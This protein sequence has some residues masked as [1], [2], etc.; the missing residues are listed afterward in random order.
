MDTKKYNASYTS[1]IFNTN[2]LLQ[3]NLCKFTTHLHKFKR[4]FKIYLIYKNKL[5]SDL[6]WQI[7]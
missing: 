2:I 5:D 3:N 7:Q 4:K 6:V 1:E